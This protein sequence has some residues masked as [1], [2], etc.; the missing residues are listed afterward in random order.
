MATADAEE[1]ASD[2]AALRAVNEVYAQ[3]YLDEQELAR[4]PRDGSLPASLRECCIAISGSEAELFRGAWDC[5][6]RANDEPRRD[7]R[8]PRG[9]TVDVCH[10]RGSLG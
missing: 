2:A 7:L 5:G 3:A 9:A 10:R 8:C 4:W 1:F 6:S